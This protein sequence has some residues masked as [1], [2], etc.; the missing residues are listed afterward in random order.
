ML[1][2]YVRYNENYSDFLKSVTEETLYSGHFF[3]IKSVCDWLSSCLCYLF[4]DDARVV[5][6]L[7]LTDGFVRRPRR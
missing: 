6:F 3:V 7:S 1:K 2:N 4:A 5:A